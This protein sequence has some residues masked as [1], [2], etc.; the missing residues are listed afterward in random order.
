MVTVHK[1]RLTQTYELPCCQIMSSFQNCVALNDQHHPQEP[2]FH[3]HDSHPKTRTLVVLGS[4]QVRLEDAE[5]GEVAQKSGLRNLEGEER[6]GG[7]SNRGLVYVIGLIGGLRC[8]R[9]W[10]IELKASVV[11]GR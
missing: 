8:K 10:R 3:R 4:A 9:R 1:L 5:A 2:S 6:Y 11:L 7:M